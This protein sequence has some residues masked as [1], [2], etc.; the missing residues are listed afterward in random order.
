MPM[1]DVSHLNLKC[2]DCGKDIKEL[3]FQPTAGR[4]VYCRDCAPKHKKP[5][6]GGGFRGGSGG[7]RGGG[8]GFRRY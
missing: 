4:S 8:G 2:S 3:P 7:G 5:G 1:F 6:S